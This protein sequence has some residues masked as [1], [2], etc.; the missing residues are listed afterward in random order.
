MTVSHPS[1]AQLLDQQIRLR[2]LLPHT[3]GPAIREDTVL[4]SQSV[5]IN[6]TALAFLRI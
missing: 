5:Y 2:P 3:Q 4:G 1:R 6:E